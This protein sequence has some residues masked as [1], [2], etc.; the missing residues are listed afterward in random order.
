V[1]RVA[2]KLT[3]P[4]TYKHFPLVLPPGRLLSG[5]RSRAVAAVNGRIRRA[6]DIP[7]KK[8]TE[9]WIG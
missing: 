2:E 8:P 7:V 4:L 1:V 5:N 3:K 6:V 9:K